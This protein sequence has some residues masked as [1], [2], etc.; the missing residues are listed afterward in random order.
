M[1]N[2]GTVG[3]GTN[4]VLPTY[5]TSL[6]GSPTDG[7]EIYYAAD[8]TNGVIW[9]LRYRSASASAYKWEYIGGGPLYSEN[10]AG[11]TVT[12]T[13]YVAA[14]SADPAVTVPLAGDYDISFGVYGPN[15]AT[16]TYCYCTIKLGSA[17]ASDTDSI[18]VY[19]D[20][21]GEV[22]SMSRMIRRT[23][24]TISSVLQQQYKADSAATAVSWSLRWMSVRPVRVG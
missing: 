9:H 7:D 19:S 11:I 8:A 16:G 20:A 6:P 4:V 10:S 15:M 13:S 22:N 21:G 14:G 23:G 1:A 17:A 18:K 3:S 24:I 5:Q 12:S 2:L